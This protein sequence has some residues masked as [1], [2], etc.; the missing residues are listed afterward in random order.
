[1]ASKL[2]ED[3]VL[4][5]R[6]IFS[7]AFSDAGSVPGPDDWATCCSILEI[8]NTSL[9]LLEIFRKEENRLKVKKM[10]ERA[11]ECEQLF[12]D[13]VNYLAEERLQ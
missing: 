2:H 4:Y 1:M 9:E 7:T 8:R 6:R 10:E 11:E 3:E 13:M 5:Y 12:Y